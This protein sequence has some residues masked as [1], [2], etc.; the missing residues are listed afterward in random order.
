MSCEGLE[1]CSFEGAIYDDWTIWHNSFHAA[2][3]G[4]LKEESGIRVY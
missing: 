1:T 4:A 2:Q 3:S